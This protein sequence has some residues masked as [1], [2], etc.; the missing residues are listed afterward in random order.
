MTAVFVHGVP[1][2]DQVWDA[3]RLALGVESRALRLPGFGAPLPPGF[4]ATKDD[5]AD[6]LDGELRRID[7]PIDLVGHDWG[8]ALVLRVATASDLELRSWV[9]DAVDGFHP[10]YGYH[11]IARVWQTPGAG[12]DWMAQVLRA[13]PGA[14]GS[15]STILGGLGVPETAARAI[16]VDFDEVM[17]EAILDL[18]RS[19]VPGRGGGWKVTGP[20]TAPG[21]VLIAAEG[22]FTDPAAA[23]EV[24]AELGARVEVFDGVGHWWMLQAPDRTAALL[25]RFWASL[26]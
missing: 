25:R 5:Y 10:G 4:G 11:D 26:D 15:L 18:Y 7:G 14:P 6:W 19:A 13:D 23:R 21:L 2:T 9:A 8:S 17:A 16:E 24:A 3:V 20:T 22:P 12:E 1:E